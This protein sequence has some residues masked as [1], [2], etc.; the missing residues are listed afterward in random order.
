MSILCYDSD[1]EIRHFSVV[2]MV[3]YVAGLLGETTVNI[4]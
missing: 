1:T 4:A 3:I 2:T